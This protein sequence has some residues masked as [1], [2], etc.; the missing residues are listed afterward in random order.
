MREYGVR[1][2]V[3][4]PVMIST[5]GHALAGGCVADA[6]AREL[7]PLAALVTPNIPEA[8][9]LLG[10]GAAAS[11]GAAEA[12][13]GGGGGGGEITAIE[14]VDDMKAAARALHA[15]GPRALPD[16]LAV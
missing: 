11:G 8:L 1:N 2:L 15:L 3:V 6:M 7:L 10:R 13:G 5:S 14:T 16:P 9:V 12:S 4:D